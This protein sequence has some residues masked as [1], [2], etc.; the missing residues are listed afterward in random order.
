MVNILR[1]AEFPL[2]SGILC[3]CTIR[4]NKCKCH[5]LIPREYGPW[6][7]KIFYWLS[8]VE[9]ILADR[10]SFLVKIGILL[11][12]TKSGGGSL[13]LAD[14]HPYDS[15]SALDWIPLFGSDL[16]LMGHEHVC[17]ANK[18]SNQNKAEALFYAERLSRSC[19]TSTRAMRK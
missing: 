18:A 19:T 5:A 9:M 3:G 7:D 4:R 13:G 6:R 8:S 10:E 11:S 17:S 1:T 15:L 14:F 16:L 2:T 12:G